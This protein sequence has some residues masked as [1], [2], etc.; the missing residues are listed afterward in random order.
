V[1][2]FPQFIWDIHKLDKWHD[3]TSFDCGKPQ[4]NEW[5]LRFAGQ[6][7]RRDLSR[8]YVA[9]R[10]G[11]SKIFGYYALSN[12]QVS[13]EAL[14]DD[15]AKGL[16]AIDIPVILLGRLAVDKSVQGQGLGEYLLIDALRRAAYISRHIGIRAVEVHAIDESARRFY[17]KYGF[18]SL[19]DDRC[20]LFLPIQVIRKLNLPPL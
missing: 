16:P 15:Q 14:P 10:Q 12:H 19:T 5:L 20:H 2:K 7:E 6:Y 18:V 3:K 1:G 17:L 11:E 8:T 4:L 9:L 13:C